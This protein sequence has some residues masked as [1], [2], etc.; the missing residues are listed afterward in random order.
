MEGCRG[1]EAHTREVHE[2][3]E[4][5]VVNGRTLSF[6]SKGAE[7]FGPWM[8]VENRR[9]R[10]KSS[11][12]TDH[13]VGLVARGRT[14]SR[15][16]VLEEQEESAD[17][18]NDRG[19]TMPLPSGAVAP[20][21][22]NTAYMAS[23]PDKTKKKKKVME[24]PSERVVLPSIPGQ[25]TLVVDREASSSKEIHKA[26]SI[27]EDGVRNKRTVGINI[28]KSKGGVTRTFKDKV[29]GGVIASG[30][31]IGTTA[32]SDWARGITE[33]V[34]SLNESM[35]QQGRD[36]HA[37]THV[38]SEDP[39]DTEGIILVE[40]DHMDE[41]DVEAADEADVRRIAY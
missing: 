18:T 19:D 15:F 11:S 13:P 17:V 33:Q 7:L 38:R 40:V 36:T 39:P 10:T 23:N 24:K 8:V 25:R 26:V 4:P 34:D 30:H 31:N 1:L 6:S 28:S 35:V 14:S 2:N 3:S 20:I 5:S 22:R 29:Y 12:V 32:S 37:A 27:L 16:G 9:R 21:I 41:S